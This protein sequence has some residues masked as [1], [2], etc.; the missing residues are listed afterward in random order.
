MSESTFSMTAKSFFIKTAQGIVRGIDLIMKS[1]IAVSMAVMLGVICLQVFFRYGLGSSLSWP[2]EMARFAMIWS[3]LLAATYVHLERG[4]LSL[5]FFV[6]FMPFK[7][8]ILLQILMN[9][10]IIIFLIVV[11]HYGLQGAQ[12][13]KSLNTGALGISRAIPYMAMPFGCGMLAVASLS[14]ILQDIIELIRK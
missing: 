6:R 14:L 7:V 4:H 11:V 9:L 2:E 8:K 1:V 12:S 5:E 10:I 3:S 13:L